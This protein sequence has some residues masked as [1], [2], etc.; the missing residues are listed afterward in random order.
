[1]GRIEAKLEAMGL[2]LPEPLPLPEG[3]VLPFPWVNVRGDRAFISGHGPQ[4]ADGKLSELTG[5]VGAEVTKAQGYV[6]ARMTLL[7][8]LGSLKRELGD[9]DRVIGWNRILGMVNVAPGFIETS[10]VI[11]GASDLILELYGKDAGSHARSAIGVAELPFSLPVEIEGEV[12][13][14]T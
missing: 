10:A 2:E 13:I 7:A 9:L 14:A 6:L 8:M 4:E 3:L 5:K 12:T 1:M 11:N